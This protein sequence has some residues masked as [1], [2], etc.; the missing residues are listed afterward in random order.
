[1]I[2]SSAV[3]IPVNMLNGAANESVQSVSVT[4]AFIPTRD[5][6]QCAVTVHVPDTSGHAPLLPSGDV[7]PGGDELEP[8]AQRR[9]KGS[10][11]ARR[12]R[13]IRSC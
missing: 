10:S 9:Q 6:S 1:V 8:H 12:V 3:T 4:T 2:L 7:A 5:E 11:A 13:A